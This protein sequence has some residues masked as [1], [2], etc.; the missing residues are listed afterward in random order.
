MF[1]VFFC[2]S[3][4]SSTC[5]ATSCI[6]SLPTASTHRRL[7]TARCTS[8]AFGATCSTCCDTGNPVIGGSGRGES[9]KGRVPP[10][11]HS[12]PNF[13]SF[14]ERFGQIVRWHS[15]HRGCFPWKSSIRHRI[16]YQVVHTSI[17]LRPVKTGVVVLTKLLKTVMSR[18][19]TW[20]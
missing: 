8:T 16:R 19:S 11:P 17:L 5:G 7:R 6:Q 18:I 4:H 15:P 13:C 12:R 2:R 10:T 14:L 9:R 1:L 20:K 3:L